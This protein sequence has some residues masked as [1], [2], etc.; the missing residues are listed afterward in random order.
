MFYH[1]FSN[2][3]LERPISPLPPVPPPSWGRKFISRGG[4]G[5]T[6]TTPLGTSLPYPWGWLVLA[7]LD[8]V[9]GIHH[10]WYPLMLDGVIVG[11]PICWAGLAGLAGVSS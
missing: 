1:K 5:Y 10:Y 2:G 3:L 9:E 6:M 4:G 8:S 7:T 11:I